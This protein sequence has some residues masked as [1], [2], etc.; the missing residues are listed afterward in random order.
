M[1]ILYR[2]SPKTTNI[3][4]IRTQR[5]RI[6]YPMLKFNKKSRRKL[7]KEIITKKTATQRVI[8]INN[9]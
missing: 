2:G 8:S 6:N 5:R 7:E 3:I 4:I 9:W 1:K